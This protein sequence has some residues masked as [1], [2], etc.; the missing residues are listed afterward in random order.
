MQL[1]PR[2][3]LKKSVFFWSNSYTIDTMIT[4]LIEM[5]ELQ[6]FGYMTAFTI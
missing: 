6:N 5:L 1:E 2:P 3:P 4:S